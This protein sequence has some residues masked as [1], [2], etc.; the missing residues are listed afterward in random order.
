MKFIPPFEIGDIIS[1]TEIIESFKVGNMGGMRRS[2]KLA[3]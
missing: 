1:N 3:H 2:K